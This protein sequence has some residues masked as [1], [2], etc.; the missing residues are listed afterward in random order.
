MIEPFERPGRRIADAGVRIA[1]QPLH[2]RARRPIARAADGIEGVAAHDAAVAKKLAALA[3]KVEW[4]E[5]YGAPSACKRKVWL[6]CG[7]DLDGDGLPEAIVSITWRVLLN[8]STCK[9]SG[10]D[11]NNYWNVTYHLLVSANPKQ[12]RAV[13]AL[14]SESDEFPGT[15]ASASFVRLRDGRAGV[16]TSDSTEASDTGCVSGGITIYALDHG[17]LR[18][19]ESRSEASPCDAQ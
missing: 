4:S 13:A 14:G 18:K 5:G 7:P 19:I 10:D 12:Q 11:T 1:D 17:K 2:D 8:N 15:S 3:G 9:T 16:E 6:T